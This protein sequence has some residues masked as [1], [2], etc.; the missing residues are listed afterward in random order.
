MCDLGPQGSVKHAN[1]LDRTILPDEVATYL[2]WLQLKLVYEPLPAGSI[3]PND[4]HVFYLTATKK[5]GYF[6]P[7]FSYALNSIDYRELSANI[8]TP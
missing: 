2:C 4:C 3:E 6:Y 5:G 7:P 1:V 8:F